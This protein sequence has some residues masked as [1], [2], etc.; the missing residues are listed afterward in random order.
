MT[1]A[2]LPAQGSRVSPIIGG[3]GPGTVHDPEQP[4]D[5][6]LIGCDPHSGD[7]TVRIG[8]GSTLTFR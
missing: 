2:A 1:A 4:G 5:G 6:S 3:R 7:H 8:V